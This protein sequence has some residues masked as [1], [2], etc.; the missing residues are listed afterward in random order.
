MMASIG[1]VRPGTV[2]AVVLAGL[3]AI[4]GGCSAPAAARPGEAAAAAKADRVGVIVMAHG[5][6]AA[7]NTEVERAVE[8]LR[9]RYDVEVAFGMAECSTLRAAAERLEARGAAR[10]VVVRLFVR[11]ESFVERTRYL[12]GLRADPPGGVPPRADC[13]V[14]G[15]AHVLCTPIGTRALVELTPAL[16]GDPLLGPILAERAAGLSRDPS[17]EAVLLLSHG[18][19][20]DDANARLA[21]DMDR[22]LDSVRQARPFRLVHAETLRE[23]WPE[24][25]A[26]AEERIRAFMDGARAKDLRVIVIPY[27]V[28]GF[29]P[30]AEVLRGYDFAFDGRGFL[31][32]ANV[33]AWIEE[34]IRA[35]APGG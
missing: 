21:A 35:A 27:R 7:W 34:R 10:L 33:T 11:S 29:G 1:I 23:D 17:N 14:E 3:L 26:A 31:P 32:H 30:Y 24:K 16:D 8:P 20:E 12:L 2:A 28:V 22:L 4:V 19:G 18:L 15:P 9:P 13:C 6:D 25:R 5:G